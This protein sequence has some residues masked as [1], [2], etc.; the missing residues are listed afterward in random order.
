[1]PSVSGIAVGT[2]NDAENKPNKDFMEFIFQAEEAFNKETA[3]YYH[4]NYYQYEE[5]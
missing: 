2:E 5:K 3:S 4:A 1:M